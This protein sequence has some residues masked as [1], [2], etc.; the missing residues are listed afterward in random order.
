MI[1]G[2]GSGTGSVPLTNGSRSRRPKNIGT[3][4][5]PQH[6][7]LCWKVGSEHGS[8][9]TMPIQST[10]RYGTHI[11][12]ILELKSEE[13]SKPGRY[14]ALRSLPSLQT[15]LHKIGD[16]R[17]P[18]LQ[19]VWRVSKQKKSVKLSFQWLYSSVVD[20][21]YQARKPLILTVFWLHYDFLFLNVNVTSK[22][23]LQGADDK[24]GQTLWTHSKQ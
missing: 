23:H 10:W 24:L 19:K 8:A 14:H 12:A 21:D 1:E 17:P 13:E 15:L 9:S 5:D 16:G 11:L 18:A 3:D 22:K 7:A 20:P 2:S 4:P 6:W